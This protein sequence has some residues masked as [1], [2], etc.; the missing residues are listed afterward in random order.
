[1]LAAGRIDDITAKLAGNV[2]IEITV[3]GDTAVALDVLSE[4]PEIKRATCDGRIIHAEYA[5]QPDEV[6]ELL[7][8]LINRGVRVLSFARIEA[9]LEDIFLK[10]TRGVVA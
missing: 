3:K 8:Y 9:D 4:R 10:V 5:G 2:M 6:D 7:E 1:M